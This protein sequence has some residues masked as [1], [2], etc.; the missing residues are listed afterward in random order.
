LLKHTSEEGEQIWSDLR[1]CCCHHP[2]NT[3]I[4]N[5]ISEIR[6]CNTS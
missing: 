5:M 2:I 4:Y 3:K 6:Q 1:R